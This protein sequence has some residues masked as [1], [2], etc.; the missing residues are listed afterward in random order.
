MAE[1]RLTSWYGKYLIIHDG[2]Y[3]SQVVGRISSIN[4]RTSKV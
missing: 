3:T 4:N 1:I 2:F